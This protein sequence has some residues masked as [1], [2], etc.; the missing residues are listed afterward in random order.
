[1]HYRNARDLCVIS[2][3]NSKSM[4]GALSTRIPVLAN[5]STT[6]TWSLIPRK[7][8]SIPEEEIGCNKGGISYVYHCLTVA[9]LDGNS[10]DFG[11][12]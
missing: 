2:G 11:E 7:P 9:K 8:M 5:R 3:G 6:S 4:Q 10:S 1:M 12:S